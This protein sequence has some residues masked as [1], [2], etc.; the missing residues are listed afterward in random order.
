MTITPLRRAK[1]AALAV[2]VAT[3][4]VSACGGGGDSSSVSSPDSPSGLVEGRTLELPMGSTN[5]TARCTGKVSADTTAEGSGLGAGSAGGS[6]T[7]SSSSPLGTW[8]YNRNGQRAVEIL[9]G[10]DSGGT[11]RAR[12]WS[13]AIDGLHIECGW[14]VSGSTIRTPTAGAGC[15]LL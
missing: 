6:P 11:G 13:G 12:T 8:E 3:A 15:S 5:T 9:S 10:T 14:S 4:L 2:L 7:G 1:T